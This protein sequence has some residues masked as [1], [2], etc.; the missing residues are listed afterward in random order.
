MTD[1]K[2]PRENVFGFAIAIHCAAFPL[3]KKDGWAIMPYDRK[4]SGIGFGGALG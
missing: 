3:D 4:V 2:S 1:P